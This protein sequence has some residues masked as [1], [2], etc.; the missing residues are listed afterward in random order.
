MTHL[1]AYLCLEEQRE[2]LDVIVEHINSRH[3]SE[4]PACLRDGRVTCCLMLN[5]I[6]VCHFSF[7]T[8]IK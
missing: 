2:N 6:P 5:S 1:K 8:E 3:L 7:P 4:P